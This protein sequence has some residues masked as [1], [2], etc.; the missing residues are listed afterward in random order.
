VESQNQCDK[1]G[2][3]SN[4]IHW[5]RRPPLPSYTIE[6]MCAS[7]MIKDDRGRL[8]ERYSVKEDPLYRLAP[9]PS[10]QI[11]PKT[12][13]N[14]IWMDGVEPTLKMM[15]WGLVPP[16]TKDHIEFRRKFATYNARIESVHKRKSYQNAVLKK[17]RVLIPCNAFMEYI[18]EKGSKVPLWIRPTENHLFSI[19]GLWEFWKKANIELHTFTMLTTD[20]NDFMKPIHN[21]MP[22]ILKRSQ[23]AAWL[24]GDL[25]HR[26][27]IAPYTGELEARE[28]KRRS[29]PAAQ[30]K[31]Y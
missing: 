9:G 2:P 4:T 8:V 28:G 22:V 12:Y 25:D 19:A 13:A 1:P 7:F 14:V 31:L 11:W 27:L 26:E 10:V 17:Q 16:K 5:T 3:R 23:E 18:G 20:P 6:C 21:R 15:G 29:S 24:S 30:L